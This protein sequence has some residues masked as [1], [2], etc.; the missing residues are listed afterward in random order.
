MTITTA[1]SSLWIVLRVN[2]TSICIKISSRVLI[3]QSIDPLK[4]LCW[5]MTRA[6]PGKA[7]TNGLGSI[8]TARSH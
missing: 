6:V 3:F 2:L 4:G 5:K 8:Q 7:F 1:A